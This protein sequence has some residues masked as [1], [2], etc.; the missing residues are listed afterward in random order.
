M[1]R[2]QKLSNIPRNQL[3]STREILFLTYFYRFRA[4]QWA[5]K[6]GIELWNLGKETTFDEHP[7]ESLSIIFSRRLHYAKERCDGEFQAVSDRDSVGIKD[8]R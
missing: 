6:F 8:C 5:E 3:F 7:E 2:S 1:L 4:Q